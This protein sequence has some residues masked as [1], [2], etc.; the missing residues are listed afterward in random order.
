TSP[1]RPRPL[2]QTRDTPLG[3]DETYLVP[4][5]EEAGRA[6]LPH[7][8]TETAL[9]AAPLGVAGPM[10]ATDL[11]GAGS[12]VASATFAEAFLLVSG[13]GLRLYEAHEVDIEPVETVD[14]SRHCGRVRPR[15]GGRSVT[16]DP[17]AVAAA[18]DRGV[19]G[20]A[21][22]LLG[23]SRAMLELTVG[24][25]AQRHQF[26]K[27]IGSFQAVKH[28][29]AN[30][31][32]EIE[33]AVPAVLYAAY[34]IAHGQPDAS[35][36]VSQA[37]WLAGRAAAVAGRAALQ[38]HGAIGYTTEHDLHL[39]LKRSWALARAWG[40]ADFHADRVAASIRL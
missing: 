17:E 37:K 29:L 3:L 11:G 24:Y 22:E 14:A 39:Y 15:A 27:P 9:V 34:A 21:A 40:S 20:A 7:P 25:A 36:S 30:A 23:L 5:L 16:E 31:R 32:L 19:L 33:F 12:L 26:G 38:C 4:V 18:F 28:H 1:S 13:R 10:V 2:N 35:R 6:A 8:L